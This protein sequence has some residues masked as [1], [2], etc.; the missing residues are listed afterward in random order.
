FTTDA[1]TIVDYNQQPDNVI[2][3]VASAP[4]SAQ[5][6]LHNPLPS[7]R[8][9]NEDIAYGGTYYG[10]KYAT[11][12]QG[13][14]FL[15]YESAPFGLSIYER[16]HN[17]TNSPYRLH[18]RFKRYAQPSLS[19][20]EM[21][22]A[23]KAHPIHLNGNSVTESPSM[24]SRRVVEISAS[25]ASVL[26]SPGRGVDETLAGTVPTVDTPDEA[27][28]V[29]RVWKGSE[30]QRH[31]QVW[32]ALR[33][34][35]EA[36]T[37]AHRLTYMFRV[38]GLRVR[39]PHM[40]KFAV[41]CTADAIELFERQ[42]VRPDLYL[43]TDTQEVEFSRVPAI[44]VAPSERAEQ[45]RIHGIRHV[46]RSRQRVKALDIHDVQDLVGALQ[47]GAWKV[48]GRRNVHWNVGDPYVPIASLTTNISDELT[49]LDL[50][51]YERTAD[52]AQLRLAD[53]DVFAW[54]IVSYDVAEEAG[55]E[56]CED[57]VDE[58]KKLT[59][60]LAGHDFKFFSEIHDAI[61]LAGH[62]V[63]VDYWE[64]HNSHDEERSF[65]KLAQAD[66][67]FCEWSL[68][69]VSWYSH[70]KRAGQRLI[71][72][73]HAQEL[74]TR[75]LREAN[76]GNIDTFIFV[77]PAGMRRAQVL[78][79]IPEEKCLVVGNTFNFNNLDVRRDHIN[80]K[81]LGLV[82]SVPQSKRL[83][84]ALDIIEGL[85]AED[86]EFQL[87]ILGKEYTEFP[88]LQTREQELAFFQ[89]QYQRIADSPYLQDGIR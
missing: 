86:P 6:L 48:V 18:E 72:R 3:T 63:I 4:F 21:C 56:Y 25:G 45:L 11:R 38:A 62:E 41:E 59:V 47:F 24:F 22:Q 1:R 69:N 68:G 27:F 85:R 53:E 76:I 43:I 50:D 16:I 65:E 87:V 29:L 39:S 5:P 36:H 34:V 60:L 28:Q 20:P 35:F 31:H 49:L 70:N 80:P 84:R 89:T 73:F 15:F 55:H 7:T 64:N 40:P 66:V 83:D 12:K 46:I 23:Y 33:H 74:R 79:G 81:V 2:R 42:S 32:S 71:T 61:Q 37:C 57:S 75:Y 26:S 88:W 13:L 9:K 54:Q 10:D 58:S 52:G 19:Y 14:D 67:I 82:G 77:S 17:D 51:S 44:Q 8:D 30:Q 78:F